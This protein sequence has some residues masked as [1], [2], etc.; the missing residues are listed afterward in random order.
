MAGR[1]SP[2]KPSAGVPQLSAARRLLRLGLILPALA[3]LI[4]LGEALLQQVRS[5]GSPSLFRSSEVPGLLYD[6]V[7]GLRA[8]Q[9]QDSRLPPW[10]VEVDKDGSR[11]SPSG[12]PGCP[13]IWVFGDSYAH[14]WGVAND[15]TWPAQL[16]VS[17]GGVLGC[18]PAVRNWALPGYNLSQMRVRLQ[19][20]LA[21]PPSDIPPDLVLVHFEEFDG[22]PDFD[23]SNPL[24][25][26]GFL[27]QS[28][29]LR[30]LQVLRVIQF[31]RSITE[32][33]I[34][35]AAQAR[36]LRAGLEQL[37]EVAKSQNLSVIPIG[38][39]E[40]SDQLR[41]LAREQFGVFV[42]LDSCEGFRFEVDPH[43]TREGNAC[44]AAMVAGAIS[45]QLR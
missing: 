45:T 1:R 18:V 3:A 8:E 36:R 23:F 19:H 17:L 30:P 31:D 12:E 28:A 37:G 24:G 40:I 39:P 7:P 34:A 22:F 42:P 14:G 33:S 5:G 13:T 29:F 44:V 6:A 11:R 27:R 9:G 26:P 32:D 21:A 10:V 35:S 16:Q 43:Y 4:L 25:L 41:Q 38:E 15:Q 2:D 20:L